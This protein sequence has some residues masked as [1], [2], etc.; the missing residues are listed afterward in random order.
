MFLR[1][2]MLLL[3]QLVTV[4]RTYFENQFSQK[5]FAKDVIEV[6]ISRII[7]VAELLPFCWEWIL[8]KFR[9]IHGSCIKTEKGRRKRFTGIR[10]GYKILSQELYIPMILV[11]GLSNLF[12]ILIQ[13]NSIWADQSYL[14][15]AAVWNMSQRNYLKMNKN[16][17]WQMVKL[18]P[19]LISPVLTKTLSL[20]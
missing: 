8:S 12:L 13:V 15:S 16:I 6:C 9:L 10:K 20:S 4:K 7:C 1:S 17:F 18:L 14:L 19:E 11:N 2:K 3:A 5:L